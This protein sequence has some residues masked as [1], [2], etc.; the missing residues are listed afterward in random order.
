MTSPDSAA[1][2][3]TAGLHHL[4]FAVSDLAASAAWYARVLGFARDPALDHVLPDGRVFAMLG[5]VPGWPAPL[6]LRQHVPHARAARGQDPLT[7]AVEVRADLDAWAAWLARH[8]VP[9]SRVL[10]G[11]VGWVLVAE[12]PDGR[13]LRWYT[14]ETHAWTARPDVDAEWLGEPGVWPEQSAP[15]VE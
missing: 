1:P 4:K 12:D 6:E 8:G 5:S 3:P 2:P 15:G 14:R 13:R 10:E 9:H 11:V 7:L